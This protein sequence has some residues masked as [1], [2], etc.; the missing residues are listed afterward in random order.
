MSSM[1]RHNNTIK[2][3][4]LN[5]TEIQFADDTTLCLDGSEQSFNESIHTL[6]RF[7]QM[8]GLKINNDKTC[9]VWITSKKHSQVSFLRD[10]NFFWDPII[11]KILGITF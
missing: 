6:Q 10:V 3:I 11:F 7:A 5:E 2:G 1:L 9:I 4:Q 8:S